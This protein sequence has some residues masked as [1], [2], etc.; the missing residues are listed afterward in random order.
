MH[1]IVYKGN[2]YTKLKVHFSPALKGS[3]FFKILELVEFPVKEAE[4]VLLKYA[5]TEL[6]TNSIRAL[7]E[8][9]SSREVIVDFQTTGNYIKFIVIDFAGGFD[10]SKLPIDI[11][12]NNTTIDILSR[13]FQDYR[14]RHE[15]NRF[16][17]GLCS[18]RMALDAFHLVFIDEEGNEVPWQGE[19]TVSG[20]RI[21]AAKRISEEAEGLSGAAIIRRDRRHSI[22]TKAVINGG[23]EAYLTDISMQGVRLLCIDEHNLG[24]GDVIKIKIS[25]GEEIIFDVVIRWI[26]Q[27]GVFWQLGGEFVKKDIF[28]EEAIKNFVHK[29]ENDPSVLSGLVLIE[30]T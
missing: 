26:S 10:M 7:R 13:E 9:K 17:I 11:N 12:K 15:F 6:V 20:T 16:G 21:T 5:I 4:S 28:P 22:F 3:D 29:I 1:Y 14:E 19:G 24:K 23:I 8:K 30:G 18:S 2:C 27:E 25:N